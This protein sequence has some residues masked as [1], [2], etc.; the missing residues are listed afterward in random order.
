M[1]PL[2]CGALE[3]SWNN[4]APQWFCDIGSVG[5]AMSLHAMF[6]TRYAARL[7]LR[8]GPL[9]FILFLLAWPAAAQQGQEKRIALVI[10]EAAYSE[11]SLP[12]TANDAGLIA[13]QLQAAGFDVSGARDL[14][15]DML[16]RA[17]RD[18]IDKAR[19]A[20]PDSVA[21][22]YFSGYGLQF[23][24][25]N[26]VVPV[27]AK[28]PTA[29][30]TPIE[31]VRVSDLTR[32]LAQL[33]VKARI[34]VL[35]AARENPFAGQGP[36][37]ASGLALVEPD[38]GFLI[39]FN[40]QPGTVAPPESG[41]A[42]GAYARAL[43]EMIRQG[44]APLKDV[45]DQVRL[46]VSDAVKGAVVPWDADRTD[47][48]FMFFK[49]SPNAPEPPP[50]AS[51]STLRDRP[52]QELGASEAYQ[53]ALV[54]DTIPAYEEFLAAYPNDREAKRVRAILAARREALIWRRTL[55]NGTADAYWSYL[56]RYPGGPHAAECRRWLSRLATAT[57]PPPDFQPI[58]Y[59][60]PP[61]PLDELVI[62]DRPVLMFAD[63][64]FP[65]P[66]PLVVL[67]PPPEFIVDL[68]PPP[69][70]VDDFFLPTPEFAPLPFWVDI[71]AFVAPPPVNIIFFNI[72][73]TV[74][75]NQNTVVV[76]DPTGKPVPPLANA[77]AAGALPPSAGVPPANPAD[78]GPPQAQPGQP[79]APLHPAPNLAASAAGAAALAA[80]HVALPPSV[81]TRAQQANPASRDAPTRVP[82][83]AGVA[84]TNPAAAGAGVIRPQGQPGAPGHSLPG[85]PTASAAPRGAGAAAAPAGTASS[86][87][88]RAASAADS[89]GAD[90]G[91][92][93][94]GTGR[95][96]AQARRSGAAPAKPVGRCACATEAPP[97]NV[98]PPAA[99]R[100]WRRAAAR[101]AKGAAAPAGAGAAG[102]A[103]ARDPAPAA[104]SDAGRATAG[105]A[106]PAT[107]RDAGRAATGDTGRA[108]AGDAGPAAA[109][110][111]GRAAAGGA[112]RAAAGDA[113]PAA[114]GDAGRAAAGDAGP[115]AAGDTGRAAAAGP[116]GSA[117]SRR[118]RETRA[119]SLQIGSLEPLTGCER[120][121]RAAHVGVGAR[122]KLPFHP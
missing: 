115:A 39:A 113:G 107:A 114:A 122:P 112:G 84:N 105:A 121:L 75:I 40:A 64:D 102:R 7:R 90:G 37:L 54:R 109:G 50:N 100:A 60:V 79:N 52:L 29:A 93:T 98:R 23:E 76:K 110:G 65:P 85:Q 96:A 30:D 99:C 48:N 86:A 16:R 43:A 57:A 92:R 1:Q 80:L 108:A 59:D 71:P 6:V 41:A 17:F 38:P 51:V 15:G 27:D 55:E 18:F 26:Y 89:A 118:V 87:S 5:D 73:N 83:A 42:Y 24:G 12:T 116:S 35:D 97:W 34:V 104:A 117:G 11:A 61:P 3:R 10:G 88:A 22:V 44:G 81:A 19:Q 111:A 74:I 72:H 78:R 2:D 106:A 8:I 94:G 82:A 9:L 77:V 36:P 28:I 46:R 91:A 47:A 58:E 4:L 120:R 21:M 45:F 32:A 103:A 25:E 63:F 62:V 31:A 68:P 69:P 49:R 13:Q 119:A 14:D 101:A 53:A 66:P 56:R 33:P 67:A 95:G 20:G 70:P